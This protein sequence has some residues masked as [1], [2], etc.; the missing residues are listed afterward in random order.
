LNENEESK[1]EKTQSTTFCDECNRLMRDCL[2]TTIRVGDGGKD[3]KWEYAHERISMG[4]SQF[5]EIM[6]IYD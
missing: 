3:F 1:T 2:C 6:P 5:K 4:L